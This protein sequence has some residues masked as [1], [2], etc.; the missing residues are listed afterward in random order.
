[1]LPGWMPLKGYAFHSTQNSRNFG[2]YI[3]G[4]DH[5]SLV[6]PEN[7]G[8]ALRV[9]CFDQ[10]GH[11]GQSNLNVPFHLTKLLSPVPLFCILLTRIITKRV[12]AWVRSV[13]PECTVLLGKRNLRNLKQEFLFN[14]KHPWL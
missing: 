2:C 5:F 10:S 9:V 14:G 13:Q 7:L 12:V 4:T 11:F 8:P 3:K 6:Q 1:M